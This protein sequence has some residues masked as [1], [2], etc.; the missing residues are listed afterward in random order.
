M[1]CCKLDQK[2]DEANMEEVNMQCCIEV[3]ISLHNQRNTNII[4]GIKKSK[5]DAGST[6]SVRKLA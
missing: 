4:Y 6:T 2:Y 1:Q 3:D 5:V